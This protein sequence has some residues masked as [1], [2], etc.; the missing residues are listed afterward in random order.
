M[1]EL[2]SFRLITQ[3]QRRRGSA[4]RP[5]LLLDHLRKSLAEERLSRPALGLQAMLSHVSGNA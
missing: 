2:R 3:Q 1:I 5:I 4:V